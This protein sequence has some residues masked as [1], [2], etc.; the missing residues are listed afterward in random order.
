MLIPG[1]ILCT[2]QKKS[3]SQIGSVLN[4]G[5]KYANGVIVSL[6]PYQARKVVNIDIAELSIPLDQNQKTS[7][8]AALIA[9]ELLYIN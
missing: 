6:L 9:A 5:Y 3:R 7:R 4:K 1:L 8:L 2:R